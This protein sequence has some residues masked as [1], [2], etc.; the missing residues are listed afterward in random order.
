MLNNIQQRIE[1]SPFKN[2]YWFARYLVNTDQYGALGKSKETQL[3]KIITIVETISAQ[4]SLSEKE[5]FL[6]SK[7][8]LLK[9]RFVSLFKESKKS[10][11]IPSPL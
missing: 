1:Q 5:K 3:L 11:I 8:T 9:E 10:M 4:N 2:I 6:S 7:E